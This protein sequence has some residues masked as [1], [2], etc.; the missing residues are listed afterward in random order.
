MS[1]LFEVRNMIMLVI[2]SLIETCRQKVVVL[3]VHLLQTLM[4]KVLEYTK[5]LLCMQW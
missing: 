4:I 2:T 5:M 3:F 1:M